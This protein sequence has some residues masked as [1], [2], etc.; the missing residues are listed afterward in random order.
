MS[1]AKP[2]E[3]I[4]MLFVRA[5]DM[6]DDTSAVTCVKMAEPTDLPFELW[7]PVGRRKHKFNRFHLGECAAGG[8]RDNPVGIATRLVLL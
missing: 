6:P 4:D 8:C 1:P 3:A 2:A 7:T 5:K